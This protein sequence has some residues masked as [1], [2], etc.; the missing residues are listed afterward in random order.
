MEPICCTKTPPVP[1]N[2]EVVSKA[3][4][5]GVTH[6]GEP[7]VE[8]EQPAQTPHSTAT[9]GSGAGG[10]NATV[11]L[12]HSLTKTHK[13]QFEEVG[14]LLGIRFAPTWIRMVSAS[15][16]DRILPGNL[17]K[18]SQSVGPGK[19]RA[20][21]SFIVKVLTMVTDAE[22]ISWSAA[23]YVQSLRLKLAQSVPFSL[24]VFPTTCFKCDMDPL[25]KE[26]AF[27]PQPVDPYLTN[28]TEGSPAV[29]EKLSE[30]HCCCN[31]PATADE[32][33]VSVCLCLVLICCQVCLT[34]LDF[35]LI[36]DT[37]ETDQSID[38]TIFHQ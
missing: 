31:L 6:R 33:K 20:Y 18:M 25:L 35:Q 11:G 19:D 2:I 28:S 8:A 7:G 13:V 1:E 14:A 23:G 9:G 4:A 27:Y 24:I 36:D 30:S 16:R 34:L 10:T 21:A 5:V 29:R 3:Q 12:F 22:H 37:L 38:H 15:G 17:S 32:G 26:S